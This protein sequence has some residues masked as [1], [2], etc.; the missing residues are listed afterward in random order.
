MANQ[1]TL[2]MIASLKYMLEREEDVNYS[3]TELLMLIYKAKSKKDAESARKLLAIAALKLR[4]GLELPAILQLYL[5]D[6][7][8]N[9]ATNEAKDAS[10]HLHIKSPQKRPS[11]PSRELEIAKEVRREYQR[12]GYLSTKKSGKEGAYD[13]V[14]K[15]Y[16]LG[17]DRIEQLYKK[18]RKEVM[19]YERQGHLHTRGLV[20]LDHE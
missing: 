5:A 11:D 19:R 17:S 15:K 4:M 2:T 7:L 1:S 20:M 6:C 13:L 3:F 9:V 14:A 8:A 16:D 12:L 10:K 18:H